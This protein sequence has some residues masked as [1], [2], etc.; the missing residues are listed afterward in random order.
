MR[1]FSPAKE[2]LRSDQLFAVLADNKTRA[3][4]HKLQLEKFKLHIRGKK[5]TQRVVQL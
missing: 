3:S 2:R 1:F 5:L 4:D